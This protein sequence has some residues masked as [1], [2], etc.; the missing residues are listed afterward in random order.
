MSVS[1]VVSGFSAV[2]AIEMPSI[3]IKKITKYYLDIFTRLWYYII[4][5]D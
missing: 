1:I 5:D 3:A 4:I 2:M